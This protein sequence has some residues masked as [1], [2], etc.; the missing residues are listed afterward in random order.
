MLNIDEMLINNSQAWDELMY[1]LSEVEPKFEERI[2][3]QLDY[4]NAERK[5]LER[6]R[7]QKT[8]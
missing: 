3:R 7:C 2:I 5:L 1:Q 4:L 8:M 6:V